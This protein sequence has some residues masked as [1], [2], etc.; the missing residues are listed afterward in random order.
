VK[1]FTD[2]KVESSSQYNASWATPKSLFDG[3]KE[4]GMAHTEDSKTNWWKINLGKEYSAIDKVMVY[5]RGDCCYDRWAESFVKLLDKDGNEIARSEKLPSNKDAAKNY[6]EGDVRVKTF[7]FGSPTPIT[8]IPHQIPRAAP[9][10]WCNHGNSVHQDVPGCGRI[11]SD[12][13]TVG[14]KDKGTWGSWDAYPG[15]VDCPAAKLDQVWKKE[16]NSRKLAVGN[17]SGVEVDPMK[18]FTTGEWLYM[19]GGKEE[20]E[21]GSR[22]WQYCKDRGDSGIKCTSGNKNNHTR[23]AFNKNSDGT[24]SF[25]GKGPNNTWQYCADEGNTIK[26]NRSSIGDWERFKIGKS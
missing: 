3:N 5:N 2:G 14:R 24:Y 18:Q 23:F 16:G 17:Y 6:K 13:N 8:E 15:S 1:D 10:G 9:G 25:M 20:E 7:T 11:C 12:S 4:S 19:K 21:D 22:R 26:C